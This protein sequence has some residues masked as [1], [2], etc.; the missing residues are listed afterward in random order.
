MR[1]ANVTSGIVLAIFGLVMLFAVIPV[2]IAPGPEGVMS[3]RLVPA[4]MM[5]VVT[6]L[7]VLLVI[8]N[9]RAERRSGPE[10]GSPVSRSALIALLKIGAVFA[11]AIVLYLWLSPL[12]AGA[13]LIIG[14]LVALG[15]R[16]PFVIVL[17][18]VALLTA[19]WLL[20]YKLLGTAI[21]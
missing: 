18:P 16:R 14:A 11:L 13:A 2:H 9:L 19:L 17:M 7:A 8:T 12:A 15:E 5:I 21:V 1:R 3:P 10:A 20:F 4:M 6:G